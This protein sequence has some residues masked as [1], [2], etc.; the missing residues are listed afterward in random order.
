M[1]ATVSTWADGFGRFYAAVPGDRPDPRRV[2]RDAIRKE[3]SARGEIGA[4]HVVRIEPAPREWH[5]TSDISARPVFREV[6]S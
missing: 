6:T 1:S 3:L 2:A 4:G 5:T